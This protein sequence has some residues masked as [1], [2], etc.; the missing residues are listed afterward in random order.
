L[1]FNKYVFDSTRLEVY[2][3]SLQVFFFLLLKENKLNPFITTIVYFL[4]CDTGY[5]W[6]SSSSGCRNDHILI[7]F[8]LDI[9]IKLEIFERTTKAIHVNL[10]CDVRMWKH[11]ESYLLD[12]IE[13]LQLPN[14]SQVWQM[15]LFSSSILQLHKWMLYG[16]LL[17][18]F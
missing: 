8:Y 10:Y 1:Q 12:N 9:F 3:R 11:K 17:L 13:R 7:P 5:F 14:T 15:W 4:S 18:Y 16:R 6:E 2:F